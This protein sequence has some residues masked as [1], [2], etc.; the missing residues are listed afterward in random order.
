MINY[1]IHVMYMRMY[2]YENFI[3]KFYINIYPLNGQHIK[4][5]IY[6][7]RDLHRFCILIGQ[8]NDQQSAKQ[9]IDQLLKKVLQKL[10]KQ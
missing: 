6:F 5:K 9:S 8:F 7:G 3:N 10:H 2:I 1:R 4:L